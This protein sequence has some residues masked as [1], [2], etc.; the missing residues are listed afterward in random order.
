MESKGPTPGFFGGSL[1]KIPW[2]FASEKVRQQAD[3]IVTTP[4]DV[5]IL[6]RAVGFNWKG[7]HGF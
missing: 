7:S 2:A 1:W 4:G 3:L 5:Q 6:S